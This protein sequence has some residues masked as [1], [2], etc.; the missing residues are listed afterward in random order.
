[1]DDNEISRLIEFADKAVYKY[2]GEGL[3]RPQKDLLKGCLLEKDLKEIQ[4]E[5]ILGKP[6]S[7]E[8]IKTMASEL[9][10]LLSNAIGKTLHKRNVA[11]ILQDKLNSLQDKQKRA[12][13]PKSKAKTKLSDRVA[14]RCSTSGSGL[15]VANTTLFSRAIWKLSSEHER[16]PAQDNSDG[17]KEVGENL[18]ETA[19]MLSSNTP[20]SSKLKKIV[21]PGLALL[22]TLGAFTTW[23]GFS[24]LAN[25]YGTKSQLAGN[26]PQAQ[27]AYNWALKIDLFKLWSAGTHYNLGTLYE[28]QQN[29][30]QAQVEYQGKR[31]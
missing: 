31:I 26:L 18:P 13:Q 14:G 8:Y 16:E 11:R 9:W 1:M 3:S 25:W 30:K 12:Q 28:D 21:K 4:I 27:S 6:L 2:R 17:W 5:D 29:Y 24:W 10:K 15:T 19:A 20:R 22:I 7:Q 23:W